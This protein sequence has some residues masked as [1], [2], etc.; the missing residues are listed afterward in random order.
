MRTDL[1][2]IAALAISGAA[3]AQ[4]ADIEPVPLPVDAENIELTG[5]WHYST[6]NHQVSGFCLHRVGRPLRCGLV[7]RE[8]A[9]Q[10]NN[11]W[12]KKR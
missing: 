3:H 12:R 10:V 8:S 2:A 9:P 4:S 7:A 1:A 5:T 6:A 11:R